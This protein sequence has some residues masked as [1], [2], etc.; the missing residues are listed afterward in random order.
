MN[1]RKVMA[2]PYL[3]FFSL[4]ALWDGYGPSVRNL[5]LVR[6]YFTLR[7]RWPAGER[8]AAFR[9]SDHSDR[10]FFHLL[11]RVARLEGSGRTWWGCLCCLR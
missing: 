3:A 11:I 10:Q 5:L 8:P 7:R 2:D 1:S 6:L 9:S 4:L